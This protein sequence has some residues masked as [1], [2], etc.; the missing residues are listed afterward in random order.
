MAAFRMHGALSEAEMVNGSLQSLVEETGLLGDGT[1]LGWAA[2]A[3]GDHLPG[4]EG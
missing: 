1:A 4:V 3:A 2:L